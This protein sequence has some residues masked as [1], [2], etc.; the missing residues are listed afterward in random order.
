VS[1]EI[2]LGTGGASPGV[3]IV[4]ELVM[5]LPVFALQTSGFGS[6]GGGEGIRVDSGKRQIAELEMDIAAF[7]GDGLLER[8]IVG[9][10]HWALIVA[11]L[12]QG[13]VFLALT[14]YVSGRLG[15]TGIIA[16]G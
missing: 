9:F 14:L 4:V 10:T 1:I 2:C 5:H 13:H 15:I 16:A 8:Q 12:Y 6:S 3:L 7:G 11:P